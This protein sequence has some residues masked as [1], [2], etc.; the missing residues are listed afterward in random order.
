MEKEAKRLSYDRHSLEKK[1]SIEEQVQSILEKL[2]ERSS[3][4]RLS[5]LLRAGI[6]FTYGSDYKFTR[7]GKEL[8]VSDSTAEADLFEGRGGGLVDIVA[9][10]LRILAL[11]RG[12]GGR[13]QTLILDE[14]LRCVDRETALKASEFISALC[15]KLDINVLMTTH[16]QELEENADRVYVIDKVAGVTRV[17]RRT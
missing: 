16:R 6:K 14:P 1:L 13:L 5:T 17:R 15:D 8:I 9:L 10:L 2:A 3:E 4:A 7:E 12:K 11:K